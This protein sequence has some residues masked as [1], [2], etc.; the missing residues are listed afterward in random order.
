VYDE[1]VAD[2]VPA[3]ALS[4]AVL[5][6]LSDF[7][8]GREIAEQVWESGLSPEALAPK[9][10]KAE[11]TQP[12]S[13]GEESETPTRA[14]TSGTSSRQASSKTRAKKASR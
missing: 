12:S 11:Q 1:M 2:N 10:A 13:T 14:S 4:R 6:A 9:G 5:T 7:R 8:L 3:L